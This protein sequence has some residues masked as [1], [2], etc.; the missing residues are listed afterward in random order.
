M[1]RERLTI[2]KIKD[3]LKINK[4]IISKADK[5]KSFVISY[6]N[7]YHKKI[8]DFIANSNLATVNNDPTKTFQRKLKN[9]INECQ[10]T[11]RK[12]EK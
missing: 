5:G 4:A 3:K 9:L 12:D 8:M 10:I 7:D 1:K 2:N 6:Q 11:K